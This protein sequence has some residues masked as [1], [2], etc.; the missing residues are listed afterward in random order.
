MTVPVPPD[1]RAY[2]PSDNLAT[3]PRASRTSWSQVG[4]GWRR[5]PQFLSSGF[6][7]RNRD[8]R[9]RQEK[10]IEV[11]LIGVGSGGDEGFVPKHEIG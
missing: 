8:G 7:D 6:R 4:L 11:A 9:Q 5:R 10:S 1:S 2:G 3:F